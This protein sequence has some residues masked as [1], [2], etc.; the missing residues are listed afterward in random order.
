V[1]GA[2]HVGRVEEGRGRGHVDDGNNAT[3]FAE[4]LEVAEG[5]VS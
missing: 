5:L 3:F 1:E 4:V 2:T